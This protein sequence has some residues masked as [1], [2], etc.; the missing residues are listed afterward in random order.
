M[1]FI[2]I[3][4]NL[5]LECSSSKLKL[6]YVCV[7]GWERGRWCRHDHVLLWV[8]GRDPIHLESSGFP[9]ALVETRLGGEG[10]VV[11]A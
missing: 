10:I 5:L 9:D 7:F 3:S 11:A 2:P 6:M 1:F 4:L 8:P